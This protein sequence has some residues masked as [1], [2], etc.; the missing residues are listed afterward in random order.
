M[1]IFEK[2]I[3]VRTSVPYLKKDT[4]GYKFKYV[5]SSQTLGALREKMDEMGL[6]LVPRV[7]R[8]RVSEHETKAGGH[9]YFTELWV[10]FTWVN[11]ENSEETLK[12]PWYGQGLD[13][14]EK[15]VGKAL[16]YAE[17]YFLLKF[18]NIA[19]DKDDPDSDQ[20]NKGKKKPVKE[21]DQE[22]TPPTDDDLATDAQIKKI[23]VLINEHLLDRIK[24]K[25]SLKVSSLK[26]LTKDRASRLIDQWDVF[27]KQYTKE[28]GIKARGE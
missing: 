3:A 6:L 25:L 10:H 5:S 20:G 22:P 16:T 26:D 17:K 21:V 1:N 18:F 15:G 14:G 7:V 27:V 4:D 8:V 2:L 11:T 13:S 19:T 9:E 12:C 28:H 23:N 24:V